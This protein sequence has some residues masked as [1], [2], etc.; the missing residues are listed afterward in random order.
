MFVQCNDNMNSS[1]YFPT[2]KQSLGL[3]VNKGARKLID[4][5]SSIKSLDVILPV[6][7]SGLRAGLPLRVVAKPAK[8]T[9]RLRLF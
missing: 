1:R 9:A 7:R 8:D 5:I 6:E 2:H 3:A 4:C